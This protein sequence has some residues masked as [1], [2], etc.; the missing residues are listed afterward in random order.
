[1]TTELDGKTVFENFDDETLLASRGKFENK[2][3]AKRFVKQLAK[4]IFVVFEKH[5][6]VKI[7]CVGAASINNAVKASIIAFGDAKK[8]GTDLALIPSFS[9][10]SFSDTDERTAVVFRVEDITE[11]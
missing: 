4:A 2:E 5:G 7:R 1:M 3:D 8:K 10:V 11:E 9:T 6:E